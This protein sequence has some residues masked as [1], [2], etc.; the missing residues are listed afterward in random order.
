MFDGPNIYDPKR[1]RA[2]G[3]EYYGM[4]RNEGENK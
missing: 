3:F 1:L 4:G 2:E